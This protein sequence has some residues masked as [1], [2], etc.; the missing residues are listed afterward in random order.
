VGSATSELAILYTNEGKID[1]PVPGPERYSLRSGEWVRIQDGA[2]HLDSEP[3]KGRELSVLQDLNHPPM[4]WASVDTKHAP[5]VVWDPNPQLK[6]VRL[7]NASVYRWQD[8]AGA[9]WAG[10][11]ALPPDYDA[12]RRYPLVIQTH[13]YDTD[14]FFVDGYAT[15]ANGGRALLAKNVIV[16]QMD[17]H[18]LHSDTPD[19]GLESSRGFESAIDRLVADGLV[20]RRRVGVT[21][22]SRTCFHVLYALTHQP[23]MF[24]AASITDGVNFGFV[25]YS[26]AP[27]GSE[28]KREAEAVQ[29]GAPFG[30]NLSKWT[31]TAPTF[32]LDKVQTPLLISALEQGELLTQWEVYN[33]LRALAKPVELLWWTKQTHL[34]FWFNPSNDLRHSSQPLTGLIFG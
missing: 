18:G 10:I 32:N 6:E 3:G 2:V 34:M 11:L 28:Y 25:E 15:T 12:R 13:G 26:F 20:D 17:M 4:L 8:A 16:L 22:F 27:V 1:I 33:S 9:T 30:K 24:A 31:D 29:R 23:D 14:S 7:G 5:L 21:G 19:E